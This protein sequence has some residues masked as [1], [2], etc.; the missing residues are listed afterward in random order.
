MACAQAAPSTGAAA[1]PPTCDEQ[2]ELKT[3]RFRRVADAGEVPAGGGTVMEDD[4][5]ATPPS[6]SGS[7]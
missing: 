1:P 5:V 7:N 3:L 4:V 2:I 6:G